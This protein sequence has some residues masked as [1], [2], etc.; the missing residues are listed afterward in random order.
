[1]VNSFLSVS[2]IAFC[3]SH[4]VSLSNSLIAISVLQCVHNLLISLCAITALN[5]AGIKNGC[6]HI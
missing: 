1:M 6:I 5:D 4:S 2:L 3:I